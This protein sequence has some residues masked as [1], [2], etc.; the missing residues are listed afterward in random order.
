MPHA[1]I[2]FNS[3][4][5]QKDTHPEIHWVYGGKNNNFKAQRIEFFGI[6]F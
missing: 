3:V 4:Y 6:N 1:Y 2:K 5:F